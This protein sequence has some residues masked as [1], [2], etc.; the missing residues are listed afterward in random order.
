L[1]SLPPHGRIICNKC[2]DGQDVQWGITKIERNGWL[3]ENNPGSW[4]SPEPIVLVLGVSKGSRQSEKIMALNHDEIPFRSERARLTKILVRL[5]LLEEGVSIDEKINKG[6]QDYAIGS[7]IRCGIAMW[8][9][10]K[11]GYVKAGRVVQASATN[12]QAQKYVRNCASKFL[13]DLP[14]QLKIIVMLSNDDAYM[15]ACYSTMK[16]LYPNIVR[17][18]Q[19]SYWNDHLTW[20]HVI[21]PSGSSGRHIPAWLNDENGKQAMKREDA[22]EGVRIAGAVQEIDK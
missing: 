2:F 15:E 20:I 18:N 22:I 11:G 1:Y 17:H 21:H 16:Y 6:E 4:G 14:S 19:A 7:L 3:L 5:G 12:P 10:S 9:N 8:D 13:G